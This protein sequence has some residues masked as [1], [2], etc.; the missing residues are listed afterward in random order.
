[1][2]KRSAS[3]G[4]RGKLSRGIRPS[5]ALENRARRIRNLTPMPTIS[6]ADPVLETQVFWERHKKTVLAVLVLALLSVAAWG[7]YWIYGERRAT[8]AANL[9]ATA[10]TATEF[11]KVVAQYPGTPAG[12]SASLFLAEE[13]RKDKKF[14]EANATLQAFVENTRPMG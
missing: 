6:S 4:L 9:L 12:A 11:Q 3:N 1:M 8:N 14:T 13:Q 2:S 7:G 10:T 5:L